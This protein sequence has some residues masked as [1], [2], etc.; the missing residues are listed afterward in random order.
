MDEATASLPEDAQRT[1]YGLVAARLPE[2]TVVSIGHRASLAEFH[3]RR[4]AWSGA[5]SGAPALVAA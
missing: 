5:E 3:R 1:L 2:T 4:L